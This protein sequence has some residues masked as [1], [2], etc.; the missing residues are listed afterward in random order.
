[1]YYR[2]KYCEFDDG[3]GKRL[4][5][6]VIALICAIGMIAICVIAIAT[7]ASIVL[8]DKL[9]PDP[10]LVVC[11]P[12]KKEIEVHRDDVIRA[13]GFSYPTTAK[14]LAARFQVQVWGD[15]HC[16][17]YI[18]QRTSYAKE[19]SVYVEAFLYAEDYG[20]VQVVLDMVDGDGLKMENYHR[21]YDVKVSR[22]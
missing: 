9:V 12:T 13:G 22:R 4:D 14:F 3:N 11:G 8:G 10:K 19:S 5:G 18:G 17:T 7:G 20:V 2:D 6:S 21:V 1:M 16:V 15:K